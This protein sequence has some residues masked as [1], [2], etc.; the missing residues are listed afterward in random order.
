MVILTVD[1]LDD[2]VSLWTIMRTFFD[3]DYGL[4]FVEKTFVDGVAVFE[5][6]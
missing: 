4:N 2:L 6:E 3:Y 5:R 1:G